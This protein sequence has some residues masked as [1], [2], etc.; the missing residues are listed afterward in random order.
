MVDSITLR[1]LKDRINLPPRHDKIVRLEFTK[2]EQE[3]YDIFAKNASDRVKAL[4]N[5]ADNEKALGGKSYVHIL[6]SILRLR[7]ICAH[8]RDLLSEQDLKDMLGTSKD[9]AIDL[10]DEENDPNAL[11]PKKA[12]DMYNL[13]KE[14]GQDK[15]SVCTTQIG[16]NTPDSEDEGKQDV[17][18]HMSACF[19]LICGNCIKE[20]KK[21]TLAASY[22]GGNRARCPLC[23]QDSSTE[24]FPLKASEAE[25]IQERIAEVKDAKEEKTRPPYQGPHTKTRELVRELLN[26]DAESLMNPNEPPIKSVVF[27]GWTSHLDLIQRAL[28]DHHITFTRL[29]GKMSRVARGQALDTFREDPN[30]HVILVSI[31]AGGLGLNLT[32]ANKVYVMEPQY[33]PA[34]EAQA[35]DRVH[36]LG[37]NREV[38]TVRF[39]M[40]DSF[41]EKMLVLQEKKRKLASFTVDRDKDAR[42]LVGGSK[43][44][45]TRKRLEDL[46]S[47]FK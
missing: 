2:P 46:R 40:K 19:H 10:E 18:G 31:S 36:R 32:T 24:F 8:G 5:S 41:E 15:C 30:I 35:I 4:T 33:N 3:L 34:A 27:S 21:A 17:L 43:A 44:D 42:T 39:V 45:A 29:D 26:H 14:T 16:R 25:T 13:L 9:S 11:T 47:L 22:D 7:L 6:Q 28:E 23:H 38:E 20:H 12:Y 37:Q 1:R